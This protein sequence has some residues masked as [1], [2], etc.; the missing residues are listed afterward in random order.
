MEIARSSPLPRELELQLLVGNCIETLL[1]LR[2][3]GANVDSVS[4]EVLVET[5]E[6]FREGAQELSGVSRTLAQSA[7]GLGVVTATLRA[8]G[9]GIPVRQRLVDMAAALEAV[10]KVGGSSEVDLEELNDQLSRLHSA[11]AAA[12]AARPDEVRGLTRLN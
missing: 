6:R 3:S 4:A 12:G 2:S 5:A 11:L 1:L 8:L 9:S 7:S 10:A